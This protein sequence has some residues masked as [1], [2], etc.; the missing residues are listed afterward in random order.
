[1]RP[2]LYKEFK[3]KFSFGLY[4]D[5]IETSSVSIEKVNDLLDTINAIPGININNCG[6]YKKSSLYDE[7]IIIFFNYDNKSDDGL[8]FLLR[9]I[10]RRYFNFDVDIKMSVSDLNHKNGGLPINYEIHVQNEKYANID[11]I[12]NNMINSMNN[13]I[14]D[15]FFFKGYGMDISNFSVRTLNDIRD[16]KIEY[17]LI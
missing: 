8:F 9:C 6:Y 15:E 11:C 10:D 14:N 5:S 16:E 13:Y 3:N 2:F 12:I 7:K 1:M 4:E 17:I